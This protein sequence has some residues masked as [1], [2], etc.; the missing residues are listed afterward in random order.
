MDV[1]GKQLRVCKEFYLTTLDV[2]QQRVNTYHKNKDQSTNTPTRPYKTGN[3]NPKTADCKLQ[4]IQL[5][6]ESYPRVESHYVRADSKCE[7]V[8]S[9][10][11]IKKC[12]IRM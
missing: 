4:Q 6:I 10:L 11:S 3:N 2:S 8:D 1:D 7:Y 5:H 9:G 12:T